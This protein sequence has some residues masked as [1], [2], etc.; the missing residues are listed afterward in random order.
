[1]G[2]KYALTI[3]DLRSRYVWAVPLKNKR[4]NTLMLAFNGIFSKS[5]RKP[6]KLWTVEG[7]EFY[8]KTFLNFLQD[9]G[10]TLHSTVNEGKAVAIEHFNHTFKERLYKKFT[11]LSSEMEEEDIGTRL[12]AELWC[13]FSSLL[14]YWSQSWT[15]RHSVTVYQHAGTHLADLGRMNDRPS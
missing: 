3:I 7:T 15:G 11:E 5:K 6:K 13:C 2:Y 1:M 10:I 14:G 12:F 8:K 4:G 9:N